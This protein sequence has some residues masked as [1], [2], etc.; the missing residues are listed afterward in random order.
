MRCGRR[1]SSTRARREPVAPTNWDEL[2]EY[3]NKLTVYRVPG[4]KG[5]GIVRLGFGPMTGNSWLYL[6]A[7]QAGGE[8][9]ND[10]RTRVTMDAPPVVRAPAIYDG[11]VRRPRRRRTG[12]GV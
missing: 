11:R 2:R 9:M 6:Y 10:A 7:W 1:G 8:F 4:D 3:A 5:S 12:E